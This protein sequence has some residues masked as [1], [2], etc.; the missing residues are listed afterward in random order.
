MHDHSDA[1]QSLVQ[2]LLKDNGQKVRTEGG[3]RCCLLVQVLYIQWLSSQLSSSRKLCV[4]NPSGGLNECFRDRKAPSSVSKSTR[5]LPLQW[6]LLTLPATICSL[7]APCVMCSLLGLPWYPS[8]WTLRI[9]KISFFWVTFVSK[10]S[11][12]T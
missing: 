7:S 12:H 10:S 3:L 11:V 6:G 4:V 5:L 8:L 1:C 9:A 2:S